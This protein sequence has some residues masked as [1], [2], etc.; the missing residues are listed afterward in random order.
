MAREREVRARR[1]ESRDS[2]ERR[3]REKKEKIENKNKR[4][5]Y[6]ILP[7]VFDRK[8]FPLNLRQLT[9]IR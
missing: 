6:Y 5:R 4:V 1:A 3:I 9:M 2:Q 8:Y 7:T